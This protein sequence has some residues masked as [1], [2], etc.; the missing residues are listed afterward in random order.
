MDNYKLTLG[1]EPVDKYKKAKQ[2]LIQVMQ[3]IGELN[4]QQRY[5]LAREFLGAA[6]FSAVCD[7]L[8]K[9]SGGL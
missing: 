7:I 4:E 3:S 8:Q 1:I 9:N 5:C 2:D 6:N